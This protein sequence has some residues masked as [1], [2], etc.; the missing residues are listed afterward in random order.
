[1]VRG[2]T[3]GLCCFG[4][5]PVVGSMSILPHRFRLWCAVEVCWLP[6]PVGSVGCWS[7]VYGDLEEAGLQG[8]PTCS[9]GDRPADE[10]TAVIEQE[11]MLPDAG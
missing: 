1:M 3:N 9:F 4:V 10:Q 2:G 6:V 8:F 11:W 7:L 5:V